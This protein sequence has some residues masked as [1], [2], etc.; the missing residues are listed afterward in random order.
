MKAREVMT[1]EVVA[2]TPDTPVGE[3]AKLLRDHGI[4]AVPV[5]AEAG[6]PVG[7]VSEGDLIGRN[8]ADREARREWWLDLL[9]EGE[10]L[11]PDFLASLKPAQ[12]CARDVMTAPVI[13]IGEDTDLGDVARLLTDYRIK[14]VPVLR[15]GR[16]VGIVSRADVLRAVA[17]SGTEPERSPAHQGGG[18]AAAIAGLERRLLHH[19]PGADAASVPAQP[20]QADDSALLAAEFRR[21]VADHERQKIADRE[22]QRRAAA[23]QQRRQVADLID[24]H[25]SEQSWRGLMHQARQAAERGEKEILALRFP[26][27]LCSDGGRAINAGEPGWPA[28]LRGEAAEIYLRW[29]RDLKPHGF[30]LAARVLD[31]PGGMPGDIGL[32]VV[33]GE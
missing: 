9:A 10:A 25:I 30:R 32:F 1:R 14:R 24:H 21:L 11:N 19:E 15:D 2:V 16:M 27:Q 8:D 20:P 12:R 13:T 7:M 4:S 18:L 5:V 33:W 23:E 29:E 22:A 17:A 26:S 3:V 31:F 28:T 6:M